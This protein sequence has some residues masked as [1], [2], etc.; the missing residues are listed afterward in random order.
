MANEMVLNGNSKAE[1]TAVIERVERLIED[2][3]GINEDIRDI[4]ADA[5][6]VGFDKKGI[7]EMVR[8]RAMDKELREAREA[9]RDTYANALDLV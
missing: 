8:L 9:I 6:A 5:Q 3:K 2:R 7:R 4:L 1:L